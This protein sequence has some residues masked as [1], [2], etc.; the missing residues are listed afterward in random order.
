M[1]NDTIGILTMYKENNPG[2]V[3]Q[4]YA[5][6]K[7]IE[8]L[9]RTVAFL[10]IEANTADQKLLG[11]KQLDF[12]SEKAA[13]TKN[14]KADDMKKKEQVY[15]AFRQKYLDSDH[16]SGHYD[17]CIIGSDEVFNC[18]DSGWWGFT[19]QLFGNIPQ[20]DQIITYA[21]T[22]S[23]TT[24]DSLPQPVAQ[25]ISETFQNI[26]AFSVRDQK[27]K[28]F[29]EGLV[30]VKAEIHV[31]PVVIYDFREEIENAKAVYPN[32]KYC[33][34]YSRENRFSQPEEIKTVR[35][36][37]NKHDLRLLS[38]NAPQYWIDEHIECDP[39]ECLKLFE[40]ASFVLTDTFHGTLLA[41]KYASHFGIVIRPSNQNK[42][43]DLI[44]RFCL[45]DHVMHD[46]KQLDEKLGILKNTGPI[47]QSMKKEK[48]RSIAY[49]QKSLNKS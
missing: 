31:D 46:L 6:K 49:L 34:L 9:G 8:E 48:E 36:F 33:L 13:E 45:Q 4:A 21:A 28:E 5:L 24:L 18:M 2:S 41:A 1:K 19:S 32:E 25:R 17:L 11:G 38:V 22:S 10:D 20:A 16:K 3:L 42:L 7:T 44:K 47:E 14:K 37:C 15:N 12:S 26:K 23:A 39:F 43:S 35:E 29:V 40:N 30:S 27:T